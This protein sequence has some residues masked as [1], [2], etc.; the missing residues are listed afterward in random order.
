VE[1]SES[2]KDV[3]LHSLIYLSGLVNKKNFSRYQ[4]K[5]YGFLMDDSLKKSLREILDSI[6]DRGNIVCLRNPF[7]F[8]FL[9]PWTERKKKAR[10]R[11]SY[12]PHGLWYSTGD[13]WINWCVSEEYS[14][15]GRYIYRLHM[16]KRRVLRI[17]TLRDIDRF[18]KKFQFN[19]TEDQR[20][21]KDSY[22]FFENINWPKV[23]EHYN[24]IEISPYQY[25]RRFDYMWYYGWDCASGC[26]WRPHVVKGARLLASYSPKRKEYIWKG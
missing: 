19:L 16:D 7:Q 2:V 10:W 11:N 1:D 15:V 22:R 20:L 18:N 5:P 4:K 14:G 9:K 21:R 13:S 12:K 3:R 23:Y 17:R 25:R 8:R 26:V 24:G 6:P